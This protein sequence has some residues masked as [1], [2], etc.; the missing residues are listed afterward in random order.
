MSDRSISSGPGRLLVGTYAV[1]TLAAG[2]RAGVQSATMFSEAP[3][4]YAL[5]GL[6]A[7]V[8][9]VATVALLREHRRVALAAVCF[10]LVGV[11]TVGTLSLADRGR[12]PRRDGLVGLRLGLRLRAA[13]AAGARAALAAAAARPTR[14]DRMT[15]SA[16][17]AGADLRAFVDASP[18]ALPRRRRDGAA[19]RG[20]GVHRAA[21]GRALGARAR[22][23]PG[24]W[25][26][27]AAASSPSASGR[28]RCPTRACASS[29]PTP[30]RRPSRCAPAGTSAAARSGWSGSSPTAACSPTPGSTA[31]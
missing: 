26:A 23:T 11:L 15:L 1:F 8:Y 31:S 28:R 12:L 6:A 18:V 13:R 14:R 5:S 16:E 20:R 30:T 25:C 19:A 9:L 7:V 10:E 2:A 4:A 21:R 27:T 22:A 24:T 29:A 17:Q 3:L